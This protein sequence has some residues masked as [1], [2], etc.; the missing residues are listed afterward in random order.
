MVAVVKWVMLWRMV[1]LKRN[2]ALEILTSSSVNP[3]ES[4]VV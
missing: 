4:P 1:V 3:V 2:L